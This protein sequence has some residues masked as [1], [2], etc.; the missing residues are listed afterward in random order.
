[1]DPLVRSLFH[2]LV[3]LP[4]AERGRVFTE[5][6][7]SPELRAEV[8]SLLRFDSSED[9]THTLWGSY[10]PIRVIGSGGMGTVY[11]AERTDGEIIHKAAIKVLRT[12]VQRPAWRN[13][14]LKE[15]QLLAYLN[16]PSI[17]HLI[18]AG[19]TSDGQPYLIMEYVEGVPIDEYTA[20]M[21]LRDRLSLFL[22]VC[23]GIA[24]A[25]HRLIIHRDLK[26]SNILV[27][28][29][30]QPKILDFGIGKLIGSQRDRT[31]TI[32]RLLTPSYASPE[33]LQGGA[34][35]TSTDVYSLGAVLYKILKGH[36][37]GEQ[38][39]LKT[40]LP[41]DIDFIFRK[42]LRTEPDE[43]YVSV[44]AFANDIRAFMGWRPVEARSADAW[45]RTRKFLRRYWVPVFATVLLFVGLS[46]GLYAVNRERAIAQ[47]R[48][49]QLRQLSDKV[50]ALDATIRALP[51]STKARN[52]IV[53]MSKDYLEG[54]MTEGHTDRDM[55]VDVANALLTLGEAQ[56]VPIVSN[57]G[58]P[59]EAEQSLTRA[60]TLVQNILSKAPRDRKALLLSARINQDRMILASSDHRRGEVPALAQTCADRLD[61]LLTDG[62]SN[63]EIL[64]AVLI[65]TNVALAYKNLH[66]YNDSVR[67]ARR[68]VDIS[69]EGNIP[70][71]NIATALS[72]M[73]DS[74]RYSGDLD[75]ALKTVQEAEASIRAYKSDNEYARLSNLSNVLWREG[76]ILGADDE[77]SL[78]RTDEAIAVLRENLE[79]IEDAAGKDPNDA[80]TRLVF[81][82]SGRE[83]GRI[84]SNRDPAAALV[85]F[86]LAL[87]RLAEIKDNSKARRGEAQLLATSAY[88]LRRLGRTSEAQKRIE[89]A[90]ELLQQ[91]KVYPAQVINADDESYSVVRAFGD[92]LAESGESRRAS[93]VYAD[94]LDKLLASH[95]DPDNDLRHATTLSGLY[96]AIAKTELSVGKS[97]QAQEAARLRLKIWQHWNQKLPNN[98][99]IQRELAAALNT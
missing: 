96:E 60:D 90:F 4:Q 84:L 48:F 75:G 49:S 11:L 19:H 95:P 43:R 50:L 8:E 44:E 42:A 85:V 24:H 34:E 35:T 92:H 13:K 73:A 59:A 67:Y 74:L 45:Y 76:M 28:R 79:L 29:S 94:L 36:L 99:Y 55:D 2:E 46:A 30:G 57:L 17:V 70:P 3:D 21:E 25:H 18:D 63:A 72:I 5:R 47:R 62:G 38:N 33:Q 10:R 7:I 26:P 66:S 27:D 87:S 1:M 65:Y 78:M 23:D 40:P 51:G 97:Q 86:D 88:S 77:V 93:E 58:K 9:H 22:R 83:L 37:P 54:L 82:E 61:L 64:A 80:T 32:E 91:A 16:H 39:E 89:R 12:D 56:G 31:Q 52:E 71:G 98:A 20:N 69:R 53:A 6:C 14:F 15:R 81:Q 68:A 41:R